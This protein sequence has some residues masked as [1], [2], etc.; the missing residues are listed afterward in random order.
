MTA[1]PNKPKRKDD[2][3][4]VECI[5]RRRGNGC[6]VWVDAPTKKQ[7]T[8]K[9][10]KR[11]TVGETVAYRWCHIDDGGGS[12]DN[13]ERTLARRIDAA[14]RREVKK[15]D[16]QWVAALARWSHV[17]PTVE[18]HRMILKTMSQEARSSR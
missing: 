13:S 10:P 8:Q 6:E 16:A 7:K 17:Q 15:R 14:N 1:N 5:F 18:S 3:G 12:Q 2:S 9:K 4:D 11:K